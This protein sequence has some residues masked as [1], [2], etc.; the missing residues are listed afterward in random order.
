MQKTQSR[1]HHEKEGH[2]ESA[3]GDGEGLE[4]GSSTRKQPN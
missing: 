3:V 4:E 1:S 2:Y